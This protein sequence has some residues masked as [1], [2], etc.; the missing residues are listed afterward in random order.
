MI[1][2]KLTPKQKAFV[3]LYSGNA[4]EAAAKAG[5]SAKT[6]YSQGERLLRNVEVRKA[7]AGRE[8]KESRKRIAS[9]QQRQEFWT[10]IM[11]NDDAEMKDRLRASE[12]LGKSEG[13]FVDKLSIS[14]QVDLTTLER[15]SD[16]AKR[17][18]I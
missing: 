18:D 7:I 6:A 3:E 12:L 1:M 13:D 2:S 16:R 4:T 17:R 5:Y 8:Q 15:A 10:D 11:G 14:G 9:R